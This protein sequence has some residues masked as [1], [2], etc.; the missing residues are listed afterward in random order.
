MRYD[1]EILPRVRMF[2]RSNCHRFDVYVEKTMSIIDVN[3]CSNKDETR[4]SH[5]ENSKNRGKNGREWIEQQSNS[6]GET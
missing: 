6:G 1:F 4:L 2:E 5:H 3:I